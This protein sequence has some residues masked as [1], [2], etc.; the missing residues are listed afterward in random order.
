M[1]L[2]LFITFF[3]VLVAICVAATAAAK[4]PT[5][6]CASCGGET[7]VQARHCRHCGY[8]IAQV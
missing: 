1:S 5:R 6:A 8:R 3:A 7:P 4:P 2:L